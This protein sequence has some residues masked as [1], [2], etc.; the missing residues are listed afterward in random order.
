MADATPTDRSA[1]DTVRITVITCAHNSRKDY[2]ALVLGA[3]QNQT[4]DTCEW[5]LLLVDSASA[6]PL[7]AMLDISWHPLA[8][9]VREDISGLTRARLRGIAEARGQLLVFVD[10]D[11]E[12]DP[13][14]LERALQIS[15]DW[16]QLG[17]WS[18]ATRPKFDSPPE[19]WTKRY[20]GNLVIREVPVDLWSNL[21]LLPETMP[22]GAGLCVRRNVAVRYR[23]LHEDG[24]RPFY[25]DR[26]GKSFL[27]GGDNDLAACAC[28]VG[29]GVGIFSS[30]RLS[31][32][33]PAARL[34]EDY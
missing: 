34:G 22:C 27:S 4:L 23:S 20:W 8:R 28:D 11:N 5:E 6:D 33:I 13:D 3:L 30:L 16:P 21:P 10:D 7:S 2:L 18:G 24:A 29:L 31:H 12:L 19:A 32:L 25:L 26:D 17:A 15:R 9:V 14:F 1:P